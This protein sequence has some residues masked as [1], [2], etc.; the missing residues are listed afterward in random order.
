MYRRARNVE[1]CDLYEF[2]QVPNIL[3]KLSSGQKLSESDTR[4][5]LRA[6]FKITNGVSERET[7]GFLEDFANLLIC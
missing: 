6:G 1:L 5:A 3:E 4:L 7:R 2:K